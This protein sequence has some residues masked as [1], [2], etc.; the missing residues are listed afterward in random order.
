MVTGSTISFLLS[1][2]RKHKK[3]STYKNIVNRKW[4]FPTHIPVFQTQTRSR[5]HNIFFALSDCEFSAIVKLF[6]LLR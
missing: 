3:V 5:S 4:P 6:I 1:S 2:K